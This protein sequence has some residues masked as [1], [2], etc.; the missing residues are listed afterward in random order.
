[1]ELPLPIPLDK[2]LLEK[3]RAE[4]LNNGSYG[5]T[6]KEYASQLLSICTA[7]KNLMTTTNFGTRIEKTVFETDTAGMENIFS[8]INLFGTDTFCD[9]TAYFLRRE[10]NKT[11][12]HT[13]LRGVVKNGYDPEG[14]ILEALEYLAHNTSEKDETILKDICDAVY[15]VCITNGGAAIE[16]LGKDT[17]STLLYPKYTSVV[18][19]YARNTLK[20]LVGK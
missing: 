14:K 2:K 1:M 12:V 17:L 15:S 6:E 19:D 4:L 7:Y 13:L 9:F 10:T 18:R 20:K 5:S 16:P 3:E 8:Q 11:I